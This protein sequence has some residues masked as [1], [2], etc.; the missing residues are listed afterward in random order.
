MTEGHVGAAILSLFVLIGVWAIVHPAGVIGW[1]KHAH[2]EL[3]E[4]DPAVVFYAR[5]IGGCFV[6]MAVLVFF[7]LLFSR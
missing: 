4:D 2:P 3:R 6:V 7:A 1:A 5:F